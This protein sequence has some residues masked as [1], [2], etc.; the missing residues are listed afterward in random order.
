MVD[1]DSQLHS[2]AE[3]T[4]QFSS[5]QTAATRKLQITTVSGPSFD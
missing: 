2:E 1:T 4:D 3:F 5:V